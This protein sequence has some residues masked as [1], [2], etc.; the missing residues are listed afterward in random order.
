MTD[1]SRFSEEEARLARAKANARKHLAKAKRQ[2][3]F[4]AEYELNLEARSTELLAYR[5]A[6]GLLTEIGSR[7]RPGKRP[8]V[9]SIEP[10][11]EEALVIADTGDVK[12]GLALMWNLVNVG[13][14]TLAAAE[15]K[16]KD[17]T[18]YE[19]RLNLALQA[20]QTFRDRYDLGPLTRPLR[21]IT[22]EG[23]AK[24]MQ[25]KLSKLTNPEKAAKN[26][27]AIALALDKQKAAERVRA[28]RTANAQR[29]AALTEKHKP[30]YMNWD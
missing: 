4:V 21:A 12:K 10:R 11:L 23:A 15:R 1:Y 16:G 19:E 8:F 14:D 2:G 25:V 13:R 7:V 29:V 3:L 30:T 17:L 20:M 27:A 5:Q 24:I 9:E 18:P 26:N 22:G 6:H 28:L